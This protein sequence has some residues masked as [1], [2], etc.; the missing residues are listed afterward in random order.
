MFRLRCCGCIMDGGAICSP[1][2][3]P[4]LIKVEESRSRC[5]LV[6]NGNNR[7]V[8]QLIWA[9]FQV[10]RIFVA[11]RHKVF[12]GKVPFNDYTSLAAMAFIM[13]GE[14]PPRPKHEALTDRL[15]GLTQWCWAGD[16]RERPQISEA[17]EVFKPSPPPMPPDVPPH[18]EEFGRSSNASDSTERFNRSSGGSDSSVKEPDFIEWFY[19]CPEVSDPSDECQELLREL[20][21]HEYL[22][23]HAHDLR[24]KILRG[25][26]EVLDEVGS[27]NIQTHWC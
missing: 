23:P 24:K 11:F 2:Y 19:R 22:K 4:E 13:R 1:A 6:C 21:H 20:L 5:F 7:G 15:W 3:R 8:L 25:F 14:R 9:P 17:L 18:L 12:T 26:T 27:A 16:P 10:N